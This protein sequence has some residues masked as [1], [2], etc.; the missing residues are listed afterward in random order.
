VFAAAD[1]LRAAECVFADKYHQGS[2]TEIALRRERVD[3]VR[4]V[5]SAIVP[6][7]SGRLRYMLRLHGADS[8]TWWLSELGLTPTRP[9]RRHHAG[10]FFYPHELPVDRLELPSWLPG[11]TLYLVFPDR[12]FN[13]DPANDPPGSLP[14]GQPPTPRS[15]FGGDLAGVRQKLSWLE[16]L[17]AGGLYLTPVFS[18]PTN[19]K[20]DPADYHSVDPA[21]GTNADLAALVRA[22]HAKGIRVLLDAVFNHSGDEWF[23]FQDVRTQGADSPY[24]D[25]FFRIDGFPIDRVK[26]NYATFADRL[27]NHPKL[28]TANQELA[29]YLLDVGERWIREADIDG[30]RLD[31]ANEVDHRFWRAFRDRVKGAKSDAFI[32]GEVWHDAAQ[33]LE[34]DQFD[35]VMHY[36]WRDATLAFLQ[37]ELGPTGYAGATGRLRHLYQIATTPGLVT[38]LGSHDTARVRTELGGSAAKSAQAATLLLTGEGVPLVYYG[39]EIGMEGG[40]DPGSRGCMQWDPARQ[41]AGLLELHRRLIHLRRAS[42]WLAWGLREDVV[43]DDARGVYAYRRAAQ[44]PLGVLYGESDASL[45]VALNTGP[46]RTS[47]WLPSPR[48][49]GTVLDV[50]SGRRLAARNE[51]V[52]VELPADGHAVLV[53]AEEPA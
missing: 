41:D 47:V 31:V 9:S 43:V 42:P 24:R 6:M 36:L 50:V 1:D 17:G 19:H 11:T 44:G 48:G 34:G 33:W 53:P 46:T 25:W 23:A 14:W 26:V 40:E 21:F 10:H 39:D 18:A 49:A 15:F 52:E 5:W 38:L 3:G 8:S 37:G 27:R 35:S 4:D 32:V 20:Y 12:F 7:A 51:R 28:N 30:W 13:G 16:D 2:D 45:V 29:E 22:A